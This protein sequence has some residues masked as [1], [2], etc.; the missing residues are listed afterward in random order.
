MNI[1]TICLL[2]AVPLLPLVA[3]SQPRIDPKSQDWQWFPI[4]DTMRGTLTS[5]DRYE[6]FGH[7][8]YPV[9]DV[10]HSGTIDFVVARYRID[11]VF[12]APATP[13]YPRYPKELLLYRGVAN[14]IPT[15]ASAERIGVEDIASDVKFLAAGD[16]DGDGRIDIAARMLGYHDTSFGLSNG[17]EAARLVIFWQND[18]GRFVSTDTTRLSS[19]AEG[20]SGPDQGMSGDI[21][22]DGA[23]ELLTWDSWGIGVV[24]GRIVNVPKLCMYRG[25]NGERWG[26]NGVSNLPDWQWWN[27]PPMNLIGSIID[28]DGDGAFDI[29]LFNNMN[30]VGTSHVSV[31]YGKV[32]GGLPDTT[33]IRTIALEQANGRASL[34]S[35]VTGDGMAELLVNSGSLEVVKI[36]AGRRGQRLQ[37]Q[38]GTGDD[39]PQ[40]EKGWWRRPWAELWTAYHINDAWTGSGFASF[41]DL[42]DATG[43]SIDDIWLPSA[44]F[45]LCYATGQRLDSLIDG[46]IEFPAGQWGGMFS[47][48]GDITGTGE[49][50]LAVGHSGARGI[51]F[52]RMGAVPQTGKSRTLPHLAASADKPAIQSERMDL[53]AEPNPARGE[54]R[55]QWQSDGLSVD[56]TLTVRDILGRE[57]DSWVV[58]VQMGVSRWQTEGIV[59][60]AYFIT[61]SSDGIQTTTRVVVK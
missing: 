1:L 19:G 20:W 37:E 21:D 12:M 56:A 24:G 28:H 50:V 54:V 29:S 58:P 23:D 42:R 32:S 59:G 52:F 11:T 18:S 17:A 57:V 4:L 53:R 51:I 47:N 39:P 26:R 61:L 2:L 35:D 31:L 8:I 10:D 3:Q 30:G 16:F 44:P 40:P 60:G 41:F 22:G 34:F 55:I 43:D 25:R 13:P 9:G 7:E 46:I 15:V 36:Y 45:I 27:P 38:Y 49:S 6:Q 33:N 48:L 14:S 5:P